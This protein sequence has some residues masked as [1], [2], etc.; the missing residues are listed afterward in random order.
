MIPLQGVCWL[1]GLRK[2][3]SCSSSNRASS[4]SSTYR[5]HSVDWS[6]YSE[7]CEEKLEK[8]QTW[9]GTSYLNHTWIILGSYLDHTWIILTSY[10]DHTWIILGGRGAQCLGQ[11]PVLPSSVSCCCR[12]TT[13]KETPFTGSSP[14][15]VP[16]CCSTWWGRRSWWSPGSG[17]AGGRDGAARSNSP[18]LD[19]A[20]N[21]LLT[22]DE[23]TRFQRV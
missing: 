21:K 16:W 5:D 13:P 6:C 7:G 4:I 22:S 18:R 1:W 14:W 11:T 19:T 17:N 23:R 2:P 9:R 10:L 20:H 15:V 12:D 3:G 8:V